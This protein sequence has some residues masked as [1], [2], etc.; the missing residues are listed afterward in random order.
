MERGVALVRSERLTLAAFLGKW[1]V[2]MRSSI[3]PSTWMRYDAL[4]RTHLIPRL[5]HV[6]L[7]KLGPSDLSEMYGRMLADGLAPRT[8]GHAHRV[9]GRALRDAE[10]EGLVQ[11]NVARLVRP[12]RVPHA[13]MHALTSEQ[14]RVLI[15]AAKTD[16]LGALFVVA[17]ASGAR[18][19]ELTALRWAD[20]DLTRGTVRITA[21][22]T[23]T[24]HGYVVGETKTASS[25]R[26]IPIGRTATDA[27]RA[28]RLAQAEER[29]R[30]GLGRATDETF[31]F[32]DELGRP[33]SANLSRALHVLLASAG[34]P[35]VRVHDLRHTAATL[36]LEAGVHPRVVAERLGHATP[37]LV[38]NVYGHVTERMQ[39]QAT[40]ALDRV[41]GA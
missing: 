5:G 28:H 41:L 35:R 12:P 20:V 25:R 38:M 15:G 36:L 3:R 14:V 19:G 9:L 7:T 23:N 13:E 21:T 4:V 1:V 11:R 6:A 16:R 18:I 30:G 2:G 24:E 17:V 29:L 26:T 8:A 34:L 31:V 37:A 40:T 39:E 10:S 32:G 22:L 33:R 27:L